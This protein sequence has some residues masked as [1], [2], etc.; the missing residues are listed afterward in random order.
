[1]FNEM[2]GAS[3]RI[4]AARGLLKDEL[5]LVQRLLRA[6]RPDGRLRL[7][8]VR[9]SARAA[10]VVGEVPQTAESAAYKRKQTLKMFSADCARE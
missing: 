3:A 4:E 1:M 5:R 9:T 8:R 2:D 7:S 6:H 10:T